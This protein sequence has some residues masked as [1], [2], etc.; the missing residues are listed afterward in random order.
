MTEM[1]NCIENKGKTMGHRDKDRRTENV[2]VGGGNCHFSTMDVYHS[3]L[4]NTDCAHG[5]YNAL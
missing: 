5:Q 4:I 1:W 2:E 3:G